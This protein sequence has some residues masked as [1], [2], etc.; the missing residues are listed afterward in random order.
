LRS[1][2]T[3][4]DVVD[5]DR[6]VEVDAA[7]TAL[8]RDHSGR[9]LAILASRFGSV[10]LADDAVQDALIRAGERWPTDGIPTNPAGWLMTVARRRAIDLQRRSQAA[11]RRLRAAAPELH[12][13]P[14]E[15]PAGPELVEDEPGPAVDEQLRLMFLCCHPALGAEAQVALTLRLVGGL[16]TEEIAAA[17]LVPTPTLAQRIS[18][19]KAKIRGAA[20]PLSIPME[21]ASRLHV[22]LSVLYLVFNEGYLSRGTAVDR[23]DLCD[24]ALRLT[25]VVTD[26][27]PESAEAHG[28]GALMRFHRARRAGRFTVDD[29]LVL[30][31][32]QDRTRWDLDEIQ[33]GNR[34]LRQAMNLRE[35]GSYQVQ[36]LIASY[37][38][39]ARTADDTDWTRIVAL[40]EQLRAMDP[41]PVVA[42]NHATAVAMADGPLAGLR[43]LNAIDGL[44]DYHLFHATRAEL[45][46]RS[47]APAEA[48]VSWE[49]AAELAANPAEQRH[50]A[51][52]L[53]AARRARAADGD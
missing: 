34:C 22:V 46:H 12:M 50:I 7:L 42:L 4:A 13:D 15:P 6:T 19:A 39:N 40:Y 30:L 18:R 27:L 53:E 35:P 2:P 5:V 45:L 49:R 23:V 1:G 37:H 24:E 48:A 31:A 14:N 16:T 11:D 32:D 20:I 29:E 51:S 36:A 41:S 33:S 44:A 8:A 3:P 26:L 28:L 38:A 21:P 43:L 9:V 47:G 10:D 52:R 25:D 17:F